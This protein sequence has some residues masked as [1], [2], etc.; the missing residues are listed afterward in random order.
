VLWFVDP[1]SMKVSTNKRQCG[2]SNRSV[3]LRTVKTA[4]QNARKRN[5]GRN[6]IVDASHRAASLD[7][8]PIIRRRL[9]AINRN[10]SD[11]ERIGEAIFHRLRLR[12]IDRTIQT[13]WPPHHISKLLETRWEWRRS[14]RQ[15]QGRWAPPRRQGQSGNIEREPG[16]STP[17][18]YGPSL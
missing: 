1:V 8:R 15:L 4:Q 5:G 17:P 10:A 9:A 13:L 2:C 14:Q 18:R 11:A 16:T 7:I 6:M 12:N 3:L